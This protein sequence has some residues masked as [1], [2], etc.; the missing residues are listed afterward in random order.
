M[1]VWISWIFLDC[2]NVLQCGFICGYFSKNISHPWNLSYVSLAKMQFFDNVE[3]YGVSHEVEYFK[4]VSKPY[5]DFFEFSFTWTEL[6]NLCSA[7]TCICWGGQG[8]VNVYQDNW[9]ALFIISRAPQVHTN[10]CWITIKETKKHWWSWALGCNLEV[11]LCCKLSRLTPVLHKCILTS[12]L[13]LDLASF[14]PSLSRW[15]SAFV[16]KSSGAV[17]NKMGKATLGTRWRMRSFSTIS[18]E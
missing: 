6:K 15:L 5:F 14:N 10:C 3:C 13:S 16:R 8:F 9:D 2:Q 4:A 17:H 7:N 1:K 12:Q 11:G 18:S